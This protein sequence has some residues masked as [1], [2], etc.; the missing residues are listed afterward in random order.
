MMRFL[1]RLKQ[2]CSLNKNAN[3]GHYLTIL[4]AKTREFL[5][6]FTGFNCQPLTSAEFLELPLTGTAL[7]PWHLC[8]LFRAWDTL[9]FSGQGMEMADLFKAIDDVSTLIAVLRKAEK[10]KPLPKSL[11]IPGIPVRGIS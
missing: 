3:P 6:F 9:R 11:V 10:E 7:D 8:N 1:R 2:E 5:S 4:S